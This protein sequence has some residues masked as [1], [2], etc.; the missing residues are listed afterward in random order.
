MDQPNVD[1]KHALHD[2]VNNDIRVLQQQQHSLSFNNSFTNGAYGGD[3]SLNESF[4]HRHRRDTTAFDDEKINRM[5]KLITEMMETMTVRFDRVEDKISLL[6]GKIGQ[7][8][9]QINKKQDGNVDAAGLDEYLNMDEELQG[10]N[11]MGNSTMF[12]YGQQRIH[13]PN[14]MIPQ[15]MPGVAQQPILNPYGNQYYNNMYQMGVNQYQASLMTSQRTPLLMAQP[16]P[17]ADLTYNAQL[18]DPRNNLHSLLTQQQPQQ[19]QPAVQSQGTT[20]PSI[21]TSTV[22]AMPAVQ[23]TVPPPL[24]QITPVLPTLSAAAAANTT[25][26]KTQQNVVRTWNSS[27]NNNPIEKGPPVNVVITNSEPLPSLQ[28]VTSQPALSVTIPSHH[29]KNTNPSNEQPTVPF[30]VT[31]NPFAVAPPVATVAAAAQPAILSKREP[32]KTNP[33]SST[34][35]VG[36]TDTAKD[37]KTTKPSPF[38]NFSFGNLSATTTGGATNIFG[39]L[40]KPP[41]AEPIAA[42][43]ILTTDTKPETAVANIS[44]SKEDD[45]E[46]VP[47]AEFAPLIAL[48]DLVEVKTGEEEELVKFEF[49]AKLLRF[50]KE[51][52]EWKERGVGNMKVLVNKNDPNKVRLLMRRDQVFKLC[53]NQFISKDTKFTKLPKLDTALSWYGQD[54]SENELTTELLAVRFKSADTCTDFH[55]AILDAQKNMVGA[56]VDV[57]QTTIDPKSSVK[58]NNETAPKGFGDQFKP[59]SGSWNCEVCYVSNNAINVKCVACNA[60]KDKPA[61]KEIPASVSTKAPVAKVDNGFGDKFKPKA[62]AWECKLCYI[63][64]KASDVYCVACESPKDDTVPKKE[65]TDLLS[66]LQASTGPKFSFG[67]PASVPI[68]NNNAA[69]TVAPAVTSASPFSF[70]AFTAMTTNSV[71]ATPAFGT[72]LGQPKA[73]GFT[74]GGTGLTNTKSPFEVTTTPSKDSTKKNDSTL[75]DSAAK[76]E[77]KE[78]FSFVFKPKSPGKVKSPMKA[79]GVEDISDDENV[80]EEEN[81][82]YFT[83]AIP[84]PDKV[85]CNQLSFECLRWQN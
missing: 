17:Y 61:A 1:Q 28:T 4:N 49:R 47:T 9:D 40:V 52:K 79:D 35:I 21:Q 29:I 77:Q 45:D 69:S 38:A 36:V 26:D 74:F 50:V 19:Q 16:N 68:A 73:G 39:S 15:M 24:Q 30:T 55:N 34:P 85:Y 3:T 10:Q 58:G 14:Q 53:C 7:I 76:L 51:S 48:P 33:L 11:F 27:F 25:S 2:I 80:E 70:G 31:P 59:V 82:T 62:G 72:T 46:Y 78:N 63:S 43:P 8:E 71:T 66:S 12:P 41:T 44:A 67:V 18:V 60:P 56:K 32:L 84:L 22:T 20:M 65:P 23:Q 13:T 42:K 75:A 37:N 6:E 64:N 57:V 54:F 81:S 83:P 5:E